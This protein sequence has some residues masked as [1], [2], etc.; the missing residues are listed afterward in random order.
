MKQVRQK[1]FETNSS[2]AHSI[3]I[4]AGDFVPDT[5]YVDDAG[6]CEIHSGEFGWEIEDYYDAAT[7]AA[8]CLTWLKSM[9]NP[10]EDEEMFVK[11]IKEM[12]G[13]KEVRFVPAFTDETKSQFDFWQWGY[14]D[15]QSGPG[16]GGALCEAWASEE[17]LKSFIFNT[18]SVLH[19]DN[20]NH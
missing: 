1:A 5:L 15:H 18:S 2:S 6:V 8:Y 19:T 3:T 9:S 7:K 13:A 20:D 16:E 10:D 14:I 12:T 4:A 11:V 17:A